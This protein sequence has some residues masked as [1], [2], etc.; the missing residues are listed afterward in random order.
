M[1]VNYQKFVE[2]AKKDIET[3]IEI[4]KELL[5]ENY[6]VILEYAYAKGSAVKNWQSEIDYVPIISDLDI[7]VKF[8]EN[9]FFFENQDLFVN[10]DESSNLVREYEKRFYKRR[11]KPLHLPRM[12]VTIL[13]KFL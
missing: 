9:R 8:K 2:K 1:S 3:A 6:N 4:W 7:Q 12:Q 10:L 11:K 13:N 5:T